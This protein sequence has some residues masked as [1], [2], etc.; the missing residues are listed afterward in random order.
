MTE[1]EKKAKNGNRLLLVFIAVV[2]FAVAGLYKK[3]REQENEEAKPVRTKRTR[4]KA[5]PY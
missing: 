2:I 4:K 5:Y 1:A 3:Y